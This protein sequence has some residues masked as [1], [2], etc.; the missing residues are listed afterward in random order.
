MLIIRALKTN[1]SSNLSVQVCERGTWIQQRTRVFSCL[2]QK[3]LRSLS[4][5]FAFFVRNICIL[6]QKHLYSLSETFAKTNENQRE[7]MKQHRCT[8]GTS[9]SYMSFSLLVS[10]C[11]ATY[12]PFNICT[13]HTDCNIYTKCT[14]WQ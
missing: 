8:L 12:T 10:F 13:K 14:D 7:P 11:T 2:C 1:Q 6:C 3:H 5:T 9:H 4:E